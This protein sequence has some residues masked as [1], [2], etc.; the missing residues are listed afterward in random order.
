M[1]KNGPHNGKQDSFNSEHLR[2]QAEFFGNFSGASGKPKKAKFR[3]GRVALS[4]SYENIF[5]LSIGLIMLL[6]VCYSLGVEKGRHLAQLIPSR[7]D[8]LKKQVQEKPAIKSRE[9]KKKKIKVKVAQTPQASKTLAYI[10]VASFRTEKYARKEIRR[11]EDKGYQPFLAQW[12]KF[13][14]VCVGG[15]KDKSEAFGDLKKLEKI[16]GDCYVRLR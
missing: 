7:P 11:L 2:E 12:G 8:T 3:L 15:Y 1:F 5:L 6:I 16:Y 14:V 10:Q 4:L 13:K 9:L